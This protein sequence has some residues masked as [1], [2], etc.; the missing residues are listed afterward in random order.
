MTPDIYSYVKQQESD[1][2]TQEKSVGD[3]WN[4]N[5]R[6]HI[7]M[8]FHLKHSQF[9]TGE[10]D[11]IRP[12]RAVMDPLV[13]LANWTEDIEVKDIVFYI[14]NKNGRVLSFMVKKYHDERLVKE[15]DLDETIDNITEIDN[16][17]GGVL[18]QDT[19]TMKPETL[20]LTRIAFCD[21]TNILGGALGFKYIFTPDGIRKMSKMGWGEESNGANITIEQLI[22]LAEAETE[23][24]TQ[25]KKNNKVTSKAIE[26]F[27][28][29]GALPEHYLLDNDNMENHYNQ[30]QVLAFYTNKENKK[31]GVTL[32]RKKEKEGSLKFHTTSPIDGRALGSSEGEKLIHPQI[33]TNLLEIYKTKLIEAGSKVILESD[34]PNFADNNTLED[35]DNLEIALT[36]G[37]PTRQLPTASPTNISLISN[38]INEWFSV[39]Q[40]SASAQDPLLGVGQVSGTTFRG[41]ERTVAQGRGRHDRKRGKRAKFIEEIYRDWIIPKIKKEI[42]KGTEF[43]ASLS[44]EEMEWVFKQLARNRAVRRQYEMMFSGSEPV[45][46]ELLEQEELNKLKKGGN[47]LILKVLG[48]EFRDVDIKMGINVA[49]K[50]KDLVNLSDKMLSIFQF[51]FANPQGFQQ[52]M[53]I[54]ALAR[55]FGDILEF[56]G[57]NQADFNSL[58]TQVEQTPTQQLA[59]TAEQP[60]IALNNQEQPA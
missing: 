23:S 22:T 11:F 33:F 37:S 17:Y 31:V 4:W 32:Y 57:M 5:M 41:Q 25:S 28:V 2:E 53:Q 18:V 14:E 45:A 1:Y 58:M 51:I 3:N 10:N 20:P 54:P 55:S 35:M 52:A 49:N 27:I 48:E 40:T 36:E 9:F 15:Y 39:A 44:N 42:L 50:Q 19:G 47:K 59:E 13:E 8:L 24:N 38:S 56:S 60:E 6:R 26:V 21:Q 16:T 29:R 43:L 46:I 12:F 30:L 7:Q 34:D